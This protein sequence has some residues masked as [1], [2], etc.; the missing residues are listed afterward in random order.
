MHSGDHR[1]HPF[2]EDLRLQ[3]PHVSNEV[4]TILCVCGGGGGGGGEAVTASTTMAV[5]ETAY[6]HWPSY[7]IIVC[8][9]SAIYL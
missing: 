5:E 2:G 3:L 7:Y 6:N 8:R 9:L 1:V 4:W